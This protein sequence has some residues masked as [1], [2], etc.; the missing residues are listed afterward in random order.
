MH[1]SSAY[2]KQVQAALSSWDKCKIS[3]LELSVLQQHYQTLSMC[4]GAQESMYGYAIIYHVR[5]RL[6]AVEDMIRA[7]KS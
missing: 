7:R 2:K 5:D 4:L 6:R 1:D 3:D